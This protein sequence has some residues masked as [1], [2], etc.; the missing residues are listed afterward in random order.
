MA[1]TFHHI[2]PSTTAELRR[3][4]RRPSHRTAIGIRARVHVPHARLTFAESPE[5]YLREEMC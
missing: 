3:P 2:S 1:P 5:L 4:D